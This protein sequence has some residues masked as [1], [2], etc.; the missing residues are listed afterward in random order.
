[1]TG[2][3]NE[4][5]RGD[6]A[7]GPG[8]KDRLGFRSLAR[9]IAISLVDQAS[10]EGLV[11]GI[12]G[13]WGSGKSSLLHLIMEELA[14]MPKEK[15]P[16]VMDFRPWLI[17]DRNALI[18]NLFDEIATRL[19]QESSKSEENSLKYNHTIDLFKKYAY[20][21]RPMGDIIEAIGD[22]TGSLTLKLAGRGI[23]GL[24]GIHQKSETPIPLSNLKKNLTKSLRGLGYRFVITIDDVDRLDPEEAI[25]VMRLVRSVLDLPNIVYLLCYDIDNL[26]DVI[27]KSIGFKNGKVYLEK[28]IQVNVKV[29]RPNQNDL[30]LW[31]MDELEG[32]APIRDE[33]W[34]QRL[35][36]VIN[37]DG[38]KSLNTPR[39]VNRVLDA[40]RLTWPPLYA[41]GADFSDLVW[42]KLIEDNSPKL[43]RWVEEYC[44]AYAEVANG[45]GHIMDGES[46]VMIRNLRK[47][48]PEDYFND[49]GYR[50]HFAGML[51]GLEPISTKSNEN[52]DWSNLRIS[53]EID[54]YEIAEAKKY[55]RLCSP[56]H[57]RLYFAMTHRSRKITE[58]E[59]LFFS[60]DS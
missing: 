21:L 43:Y 53:P 20:H 42:L 32:I 15:V 12:E 44:S 17:S 41:A 25:E 45:T 9:R 31:F 8:D 48:A 14:K 56:D 2:A 46:S 40:I 1:M 51:I 18:T 54:S 52:N 59:S 3:F 27:E 11:I 35:A 28:I 37:F 57:F 33:V 6:R 34:S 58:A 19:S 4:Q 36:N 50:N 30:R 5:I 13:A 26:S 47:S 24:S 60:G 55:K 22:N 10:A 29:P 23:S 39:S 7:L 38:M 49:M 16:A